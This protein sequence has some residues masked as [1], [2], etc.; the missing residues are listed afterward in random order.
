MLAWAALHA[1]GG[2]RAAEESPGAWV[3]GIA[4]GGVGQADSDSRWIYAAEAQGRYFDFGTGVN[5]YLVRGGLGYQ[6]AGSLQAW[7]GYGRFRFRTADGSPVDENRFFQQLNWSAGPALGGKV[8]VR[9]RLIQR[10]VTNGND[11]ALALRL[12]LAY[13]RP[14]ATAHPATLLL[15]LEPFYD[16]RD[17]DWNGKAGLTQNRIYAGLGWQ[18]SDSIELETGYMNQFLWRDAAANLSN[19]LAILQLR[20]RL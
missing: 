14:L 17:T 19:H 20:V 15:R 5:Q 6:L 16:F 2:A 3:G 12:L 8:D 4:T 10:Q 13:S 1:A 11:T 7:I 18:L 9:A